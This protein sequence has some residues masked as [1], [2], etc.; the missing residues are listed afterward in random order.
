[1]Q[2]ILRSVPHAAI[3][4]LHS[5]GCSY[6]TVKV[7]LF[8]ASSSSHSPDRADEQH[9]GHVNSANIFSPRPLAS[10]A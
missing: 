9:R 2:I 1:M 3:A 7:I 4:G 8:Q 6:P 10:S 5:R